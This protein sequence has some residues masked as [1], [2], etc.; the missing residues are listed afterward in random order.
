MIEA[1]AIFIRFPCLSWVVVFLIKREQPMQAVEIKTV[2]IAV[3]Q[4]DTL[5]DPIQARS[6]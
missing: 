5:H 1:L 4:P 6:E 2:Y 3:K